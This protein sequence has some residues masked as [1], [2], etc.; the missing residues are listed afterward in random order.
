MKGGGAI[1]LL[2]LQ[3]GYLIRN[4][5]CDT[6]WRWQIAMQVEGFI[7]VI[8]SEDLERSL[9]FWV[10]GLQFEVTSEMH[11]GG[12]LIFSMLRQGELCFMLNQ[13][14][15]TPSKPDDYEGIRLY[16]APNDIHGVRERLKLL[17]FEVS[18]LENREY[19]QTEF[20]LT[21]DDGFA[22]CF[23]VPTNID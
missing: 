17:G 20:H 5:T 6:I 13:R 2:A 21:D 14:A 15:G 8:P 23:G 7:P 11:E 4:L 3:P 19:G 12:K 18:E 10:E 9:H 22:H 16:W 1:R